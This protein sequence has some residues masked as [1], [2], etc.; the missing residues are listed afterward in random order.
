MSTR[1]LEVVHGRDN[2]LYYFKYIV[3]MQY[4]AEIRKMVSILRLPQKNTMLIK[5]S[6]HAQNINIL[7][8]FEAVIKFGDI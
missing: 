7:T 4:K 3:G 8:N 6:A 1:M 2:R 5:K